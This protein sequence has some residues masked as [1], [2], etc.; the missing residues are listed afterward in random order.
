M[1]IP[2]HGLYANMAA[3][4]VSQVSSHVIIYYHRKVITFSDQHA[5]DPEGTI[6]GLTTTP[7]AR[8]LR[9]HAFDRA[10]SKKEKTLKV[11]SAMSYVLVFIS[12]AIVSLVICGC[13]F[14]SFS[15]DVLGILGIAIESGQNNEEAYTLHNLFSIVQLLSNEASFLDNASDSLGL[16][17]LSAILIFTVV[18][19]PLVQVLFIMARW[20]MPMTKQ[21]KYYNFII[22]EA[23]QAW[24]Y[25]EVYILGVIVT[26]WQLGSISE[27]MINDYCGEL[28]DVF[29]SAIYYGILSESNAQ[30]FRVN[31]DV[32]EGM[33]ILFAASIM[34]VFLKYFV[35]KAA[36]HQEQDEKEKRSE[37]PQSK[38]NCEI[39]EEISIK[40]EEGLTDGEETIVSRSLVISPP[41]FTD[42][43]RWFLKSEDHIHPACPELA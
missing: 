31:A 32:K 41:L 27:F 1:V 18:I 11:Y 2:K 42:Y 29:A 43:F 23:L 14:P 21:G 19:V 34:L 8:A 10:G 6:C 35:G 13:I 37:E 4:L 33:W 17:I 3:Q 20:F 15:L 28:E 24:Q 7:R 26:T 38:Q 40:T 12:L 16:G 25:I 22:I 39:V 9:N 36:L 5:H 30:C